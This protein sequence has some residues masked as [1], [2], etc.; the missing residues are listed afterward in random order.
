MKKGTILIIDD[1]P[2][3]LETLAEGLQE[4]GYEALAA[5]DGQ[6][7]LAMLAERPDVDVVLTDLKMQGVDGLEVLRHA[8]SAD[9]NLPVILVTAYASLETAIEAM[10]IG[11]FDY[12]TK[13]ID[14]RRVVI[15]VEKGVALRTLT[16]ENFDLKR[17]LNEKFGFENIIGRS[18][19][20]ARVFQMVRQVADTRTAVL[21]EGESGTGKELVAQAIHNNSSRRAGPFIGVNCAALTETLL[22]SELF[23]HEK[24]AFTGAIAQKKGRFELADGGTLFLDEVGDMSLAMQSKLLRVL[25]EYR[26][27]R[28]GGTHTVKVDVRIITATNASLEDKVKA[29]TF[30]EDLFYRLN[31]VSIRVP[32]LRERRDD[33]PLLA[34]HFARVFAERNNRPVKTINPQAM[35]VLCRYPWPGNVRELQN[36]IEN[37][38]I[39]SQDDVLSVKDLPER[40]RPALPPSTGGFPVGITMHQLEERAIR[41][42]LDS[43]DGNR[44]KA[45]DLLGIGLRT[46]HRKL[47]EYGM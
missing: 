6:R 37:M 30:R 7:G 14:L 45:A 23:G 26:F 13:P 44:K 31:V 36:V 47:R 24:G 32:P 39:T 11:A 17:R 38:V 21:I 29:G 41:E 33:V 12:V 27:E 25:Q 18:E 42:T 19:G 35:D 2:I 28:V 3:G 10:K 22:E 5:S 46:L 40:V 43:V 16:R 20:M 4:E 9:E 34:C 15:V 8:R 1:D